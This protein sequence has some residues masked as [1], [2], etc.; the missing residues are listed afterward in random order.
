MFGREIFKLTN[1]WQFKILP[2]NRLFLLFHV[3]R[4]SVCGQ[5]AVG[6]VTF[7]SR[8]TFSFCDMHGVI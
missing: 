6:R 3:K 7:V 8:E 2:N 4:I 1:G 5:I